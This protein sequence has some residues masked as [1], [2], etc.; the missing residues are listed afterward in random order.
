MKCRETQLFV[1]INRILT[2]FYP[3]NSRLYDS[4]VRYDTVFLV[5]DDPINNLLNKRLLDRLGI[6]KQIREFE[7]GMEALTKLK[8]INLSEHLLIFLDINMPVLDGWGFLKMYSELFPDRKDKI[9]ILSSSI[10]FQDRTR[11]REF[12]LISGFLEKPLT[13]EKIASHLELE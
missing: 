7:E 11:A 8:E 13:F 1:S 2:C 9:V 10:D 4:M 6:F 12:G 3:H 5:D